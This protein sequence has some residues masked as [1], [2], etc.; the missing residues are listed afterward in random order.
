MQEIKARKLVETLK[1][2]KARG[3]LETV[4]RLVK[5]INEIMIYAVN[6]GFVDANPAYGIG[7]AFEKHK[8]KICQHYV[9]KNYR[10]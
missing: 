7:M 2:I 1:P 10:S 6:T 5:S 4:R 3:A 9:W 8:N